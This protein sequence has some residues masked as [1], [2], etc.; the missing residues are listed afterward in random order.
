MKITSEFQTEQQSVSF[1]GFPTLYGTRMLVCVT[2]GIK[3]IIDFCPF[4]GQKSFL[5]L[6]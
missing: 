6:N 3:V 4:T 5:Y 2:G 1:G